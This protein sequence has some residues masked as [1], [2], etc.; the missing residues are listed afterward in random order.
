MSKNK[1]THSLQELFAMAR[2]RERAQDPQRMMI[3]PTRTFKTG[4]ERGGKSDR[5]DIETRKRAARQDM[6]RDDF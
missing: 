1:D 5:K 3:P 4:K 2:G 6:G